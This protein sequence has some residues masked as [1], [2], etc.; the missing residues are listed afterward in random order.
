LNYNNYQLK[1]GCQIFN[2][3]R[4]KEI[5]KDLSVST[6]LNLVKIISLKTTT[7]RESH[8][9]SIV[10][11]IKFAD[12]TDKY[13]ISDKGKAYSKD[14][15]VAVEINTTVSNLKISNNRYYI[16]GYDSSIPVS[17]REELKSYVDYCIDVIE[18]LNTHFRYHSNSYAQFQ[19]EREIYLD[20]FK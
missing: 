17:K 1:V 8:S 4:L 3:I 6:G 15:Y 2:K 18:V 12:E 11:K 16:N 20:S 19:I 13:L 9:Y 10:G 7:F 14:K 5:S